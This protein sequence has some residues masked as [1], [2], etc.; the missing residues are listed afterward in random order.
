ML[1]DFIERAKASWVRLKQRA[2]PSIYKHAWVYLT[3][4]VAAS[5]GCLIISWVGLRTT[6][7]DEHKSTEPGRSQEPAPPA[8]AAVS[9]FQLL[10][11]AV[12]TK[13]AAALSPSGLGVVDGIMKAE[14]H[15][16][17]DMEPAAQVSVYNQVVTTTNGVTA[18]V[19]T[20]WITVTINPLSPP[21][22]IITSGP[23]SMDTATLISDTVTD[24]VTTSDDTSS[25]TTA[26]DAMTSD[27]TAL[28]TNTLSSITSATTTSSMLSTSVS[29]LSSAVSSS[30]SSAASSAWPSDV[31]SVI[32]SPDPASTTS[33]PTDLKYCPHP[34]RTHI[35][36]PCAPSAAPGPA[37]TTTVTT[38]A[39]AAAAAAPCRRNPFS[40]VARA[41]SSLWNYVVAC[42]GL[43]SAARRRDCPF[44]PDALCAAL[45]AVRVQRELA[46]NQDALVRGRGRGSWAGAAVDLVRAV[47]GVRAPVLGVIARVFGF[48]R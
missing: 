5:L 23:T 30:V 14:V 11:T 20:V 24:S 8:F 3:I 7:A 48:G 46:E 15:G 38:G 45:E 32:F 6:A 47:R 41:L 31:S 33:T 13:A 22:P 40:A 36:T 2:T 27:T 19:S 42:L 26:S 4:L 21:G 37:T 39:S 16:D 35:W 28:D 1:G 25:V 18:Y 34:E 12:V 44:D 17:I 29:T 10:T 43:R 9:G